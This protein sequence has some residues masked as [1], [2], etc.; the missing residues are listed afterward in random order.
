M[1]DLGLDVLNDKSS[2]TVK[3]FDSFNQRVL[4]MFTEYDGTRDSRAMLAI[5]QCAAL[6]GAALC[7]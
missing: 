6:I 3:K 1:V 7:Q 2:V 5:L 4:A